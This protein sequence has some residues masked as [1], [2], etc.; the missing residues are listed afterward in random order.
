MRGGQSDR[1]RG[2]VTEARVEV[3]DS[4]AKTPNQSPFHPFVTTAIP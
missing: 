3:T 4:K 1:S 2:K